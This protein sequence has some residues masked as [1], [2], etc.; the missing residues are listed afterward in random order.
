MDD[1]NPQQP[2]QS[3]EE[4]EME[5]SLQAIDTREQLLDQLPEAIGKAGGELLFEL[6]H[7]RDDLSW[8]GAV[9]F[10]EGASRQ[11]AIVSLPA[12]GGPAKVEPAASSELP[13]ARIAESYAGLMPH[14]RTAA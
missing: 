13:M 2:A 9:A 12:D 8:A 7:D 3:L 4:V 11:F 1:S 6:P 14:F 10:G 5:L